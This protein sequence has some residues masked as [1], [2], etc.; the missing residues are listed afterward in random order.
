M[1]MEE[2]LLMEM[3]YIQTSI[4]FRAL[5]QKYG[6]TYYAVQ[7]MAK[8]GE[9]LQAR[10]EFHAGIAAG[11][12]ERGGE[13]REGKGG[14]GGGENNSYARVFTDLAKIIGKQTEA[15]ARQTAVLSKQTE[16]L[17]RLKKA[18]ADKKENGRRGGAAGKAGGASAK[19]EE[20]GG[21]TEEGNREKAAGVIELA[22]VLGAGG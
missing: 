19:R 22:E 16:A 10:M 11:S 2:R 7:N 17:C 9:W 4:G 14:L 12:E 21:K 20:S 8:A 5:A 1:D 6:V 15:L 18:V 3:E 13:E